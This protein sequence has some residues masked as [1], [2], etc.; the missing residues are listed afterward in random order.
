MMEGKTDGV[1]GEWLDLRTGVIYRERDGQRLKH[2]C[3]LPA[4]WILSWLDA[5]N[6]WR[7]EETVPL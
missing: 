3:T 7:S 1:C 2:V 4:N 6:S 5:S